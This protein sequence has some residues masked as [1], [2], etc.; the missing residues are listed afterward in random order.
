MPSAGATTGHV[1]LE[2]GGCG[3]AA[4]TARQRERAAG[5]GRRGNASGTVQAAFRE[6][7]A[8]LGAHGQPGV[9]KT[10]LLELPRGLPP[11]GLAG[12]FA[13]LNGIQL[14]GRIE[15]SFRRRLD[16]SDRHPRRPVGS[17]RG[18]GPVPVAGSR[19]A[20]DRHGGWRCRQ[21]TPACSTSAPAFCFGIRWCVRRL[22]VGLDRD[23]HRCMARWRG[24][25]A[26]LILMSSGMGRPPDPTRTLLPCSAS[27]DRAESSAGMAAAA[28]F[29]ERAALLTP[30]PDSRA[31]RLLAAASGKRAA[32]TLDADLGCWSPS[33][34]ARLTRCGRR[35]WSTCAD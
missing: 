26:R 11:A 2:T 33:R 10:A 18:T 5:L 1:V 3:P 29:L 17:G 35:R 25:D 7:R 8:A 4:P 31:R 19:A 22:P 20:R 21:P 28:A 6:G 16:R 24:P 13:F 30:E 34:P 32:A 12:G 9:G 14:P 23:R 15:E 27:A